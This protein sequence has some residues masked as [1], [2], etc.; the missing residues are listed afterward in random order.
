[1]HHFSWHKL[2]E[3]FAEKTTSKSQSCSFIYTYLFDFCFGKP[4]R[5]H[6]QR[7]FYMFVAQEYNLSKNFRFQCIAC[8]QA[9]WPHCFHVLARNCISTQLSKHPGTQAADTQRGHLL[10]PSETF[11]RRPRSLRISLPRTQHTGLGS[12]TGELLKD[13]LKIKYMKNWK[14]CI[15]FI[16][17]VLN[18]WYLHYMCALHDKL[19]CSGRGPFGY[20]SLRKFGAKNV[21]F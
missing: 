10:D 1:M 14:D 5:H 8:C 20:R 4:H 16:S 18:Y 19:T 12:T 15:I 6:N 11:Q 2:K 13:N 3:S 17:V 9:T 21:F 7:N